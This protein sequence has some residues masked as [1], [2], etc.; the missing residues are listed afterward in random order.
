MRDLVL[1]AVSVMASRPP[2]HSTV[3]VRQREACTSQMRC[4]R[5]VG[6][7]QILGQRQIHLHLATTDP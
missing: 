1:M 5:E 2:R 7:S 6:A 4:S 3:I